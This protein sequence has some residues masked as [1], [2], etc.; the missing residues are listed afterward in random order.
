MINQK[1]PLEKVRKI[2]R[3]ERLHIA[4]LNTIMIFRKKTPQNNPTTN[5]AE[6]YLHN[7][8]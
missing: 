7:F 8:S 3:T 1:A 6:Y 4:R 2:I 5:T